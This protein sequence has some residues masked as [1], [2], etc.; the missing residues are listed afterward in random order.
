MVAD[1]GTP[2]GT[3]PDGGTAER[4]D[5]AHHA[6]T[7]PAAA[8]PRR[9]SP[10]PVP[11]WDYRFHFRSGSLALDLVATVGERWRR[12]FDRLRSPADLARWCTES[13]LTD[14]ALPVGDA[15]LAAVR[16]LREAIHALASAAIAGRDGASADVAIVNVHAGTPP[17]N[18]H[19]RS[20]GRAEGVLA[21]S[22]AECAGAIAADA[23]EL[24]GRRP[25]RIRECDAHDCGI[26]FVDRS[27]PGTRR[28]CAMRGCGD[29]AKAA[30][31][32]RRTAGRGPRRAEDR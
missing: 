32:R 13:G 3:T 27:R 30:A 5:A 28:W 4:T 20:I 25:D 24:L 10:G 17:P 15:D 22:V 1:A 2:T 23:V 16:E 6:P 9:D 12:N 8:P 19:L 11:T 31:Y 29:K 18:P 21:R 26:L 14:R 7:V